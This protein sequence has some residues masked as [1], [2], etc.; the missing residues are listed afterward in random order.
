M[1]S[2]CTLEDN[3]RIFVKCRRRMFKKT[4]Q[5]TEILARGNTVYSQ[6][7]ANEK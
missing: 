6:S 7:R 5:Y 4:P 2:L 3:Q 1:F